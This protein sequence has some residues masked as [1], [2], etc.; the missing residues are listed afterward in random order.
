M[1]RTTLAAAAIAAI[2]ATA[3]LVAAAAVTA[4]WHD[5]EARAGA[6]S[7]EGDSPPPTPLAEPRVWLPL[8]L[9]QRL[10]DMP[11]STPTH[12]P[13]ATET[14][15][16]TPTSTPTATPTATPTSTPTPAPVRV[17]PNHT[18]Y[19]DGEGTLHIVGEVENGTADPVYRI[20]LTVQ[21]FSSD[22]RVVDTGHGVASLQH[23]APG[24]RTCF[25]VSMVDPGAW[26]SY[27]FEAPSYSPSPPPPA[28]SVVSDSGMYVPAVGWYLLA[29]EVRNDH[30]A[31]V[32]GVT[33][34]GTLYDEAGGVVGCGGAYVLSVGLDPNETGLFELQFV[35]RDFGDVTIYRVQADGEPE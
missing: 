13:T 8:V 26:S 22:G 15:T 14:S 31:R 6:M 33:A 1:K 18:H 11:T 7:G 2:A 29:G 20:G 5:A 30:G 19:V 10:A 35:G 9:T 12:T 21:L 24:E 25:H 32:N 3:A 28:L 34:V 16:A 23:L 4:P 27:A 17:L